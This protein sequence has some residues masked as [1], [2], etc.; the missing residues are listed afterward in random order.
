M[1]GK[2]WVMRFINVALVQKYEVKWIGQVFLIYN[3]KILKA[4]RQESLHA[5]NLLHAAP[6]V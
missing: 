4:Q 6:A 1:S 2:I 5:F 3:L